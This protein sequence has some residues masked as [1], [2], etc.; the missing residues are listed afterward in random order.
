MTQTSTLYDLIEN[1]VMT[2]E[3]DSE[4][5]IEPPLYPAVR[6]DPRLFSTLRD[7]VHTVSDLTNLRAQGRL[8]IEGFIGD[9]GVTKQSLVRC[10]IAAILL[11]RLTRRR[12][13][14]GSADGMVTMPLDDVGLQDGVI[15]LHVSND[16][17]Q[18]IGTELGGLSDQFAIGQL[19]EVEFDKRYRSVLFS[20]ELSP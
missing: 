6:F 3:I 12:R 2:A 18:L 8:V 19:D 9:W 11:T 17:C 5:A 14:Y 10:R 13:T 16:E 4:E 20:G 7:Q 1:L 15:S